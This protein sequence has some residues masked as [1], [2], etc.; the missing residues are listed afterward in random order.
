MKLVDDWSAAWRWFSMQAM[1]LN[2][3]FLATWA[4]MPDEIKTAMPSW[5]M[6]VVAI[7]LLLTGMIGRLVQQTPP[8]KQ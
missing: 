8:E 7:A 2:V 6:P 5:L 1:G 4:V 3:A